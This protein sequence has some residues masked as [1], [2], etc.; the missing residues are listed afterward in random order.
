MPSAMV[1]LFPP[2]TPA[3]VSIAGW[4][5]LGVVALLVSAIVR[6]TPLAV[7]P[8]TVGMT[9]LQWALYVGWSLFNLYAEGYKGFQK[10]FVPRAVARAFYLARY[11]RPLHVALAPLFCMGLFYANRKRLMLSWGLVI[12]VTALVTLVRGL[13]QPWRG[14]VD[15]GVVLGLSYGT[16]ALLAAFFAVLRG[17]PITVSPQVPDGAPQ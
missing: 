4:G 2:R 17:R 9:P 3:A 5:M 14:I 15:A 13:D 7:E 10:A 11:P 6:L 12:G 16:V 8:L 1:R